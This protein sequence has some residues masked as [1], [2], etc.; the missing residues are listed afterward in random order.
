MDCMY[1]FVSGYVYS[2]VC[3]RFIYVWYMNIPN[4][5]VSYMFGIVLTLILLAVTHCMVVSSF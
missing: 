4:I 3:V 1:S 2:V 5:Y